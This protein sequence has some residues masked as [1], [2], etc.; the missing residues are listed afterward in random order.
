M[1]GL[2][3]YPSELKFQFELG[4]ELT[5]TISLANASQERRAFKVMTTMPEKYC[6]RPC[7]GIVEPNS[8]IQAEV[9]LQAY[10]EVPPDVNDCADKFL[11][12]STVVGPDV[13]QVTDSTFPSDPDEAMSDP[14]IQEAHLGVTLELSDSPLLLKLA[15]Q[16]LGSGPGEEGMS[17]DD[18]EGNEVQETDFSL[19]GDSR[20]V[21]RFFSAN[22][23]FAAVAKDVLMDH[24]DKI[25][26]ERDEL[27]RQVDILSPRCTPGPVADA[28]VEPI[29][30]PLP[31]VV[32]EKKPS[33]NGWPAVVAIV[34]SFLLGR[35][36]S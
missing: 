25:M 4:K 20:R 15:L 6:V 30:Q 23:D 18:E 12:Q 33:W 26:R 16:T 21:H 22:S 14:S 24:L 3:V 29:P 35:F 2:Q 36:T 31:Q 34:G 27:K 5:T 11:V 9:F 19:S 8:S 32:P 10:A 1:E 13:N 28:V 17:E 7:V